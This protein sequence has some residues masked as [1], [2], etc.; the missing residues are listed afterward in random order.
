MISRKEIVMPQ[1]QIDQQLITQIT[2][3]EAEPENQTDALSHG[4]VSRHL[5]PLPRSADRKRSP[6]KV[7]QKREYR[8]TWLE[9]F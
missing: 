7:S 8:G 5:P 4:E 9:T 2:I 3:I 1:I 6:R